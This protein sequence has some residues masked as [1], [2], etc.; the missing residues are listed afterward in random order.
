MKKEKQNHSPLGDSLSGEESIK[1][2]PDLLPAGSPSGENKSLSDFDL[3]DEIWKTLEKYRIKH[4]AYLK[5]VCKIH[6]RRMNCSGCN[7]VF[8]IMIEINILI[9]KLAERLK[10]DRKQEFE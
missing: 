8:E 5:R 10:N 2:I 3:S 6:N 9:Q 4:C 7:T 1:C